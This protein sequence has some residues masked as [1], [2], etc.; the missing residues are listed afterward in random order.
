MFSRDEIRTLRAL[1]EDQQAREIL[2][3]WTLKE[4]Y[5]KA[6]GRGLSLP[7]NEI[8]F[9]LDAPQPIRAVIDPRLDPDHARWCFELVRPTPEHQLAVAYEAGP[10]GRGEVRLEWVV[11]LA[12]R[13]LSEA[14]VISPE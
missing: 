8:T 11:P 10:S 3:V 1:P 13:T 12:E 6:R 4:A 2:C 7:F 5:A 9:D 14:V